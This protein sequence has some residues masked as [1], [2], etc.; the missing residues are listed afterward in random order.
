[1]N[2]L[3]VVPWD[4]ASGGVASVVGNLAKH[5]ERR[6]HSVVFLHPGAADGRGKRVTAMGFTGYEIDFRVPFVKGRPVRSVLGF[7]FY[8]AR[9]LYQIASVIRRHRIQVVNIHY[10]TESFGYIG[11]LRWLLPMRLAISVHGADLFPDG[12]GMERYPFFLKFLVWSSDAVIAPSEAFLLA[13]RS[14]F[15]GAAKKSV[16]IHNGV[17]VEEFDR[18]DEGKT[19][20]ASRPYLLCIAAHNEKKALEVLLEA[21]AQ[22]SELH[23]E[24]RLLLVG[25]GPLR[26]KNEEHARLLSLEHRVEFL[27]ER[28]RPEIGRLLRGC[29]FFVLPSRSEPFGMVIAEAMACH[30]AVVASAVG[31]IPEIV[32]N[33]KSGIL[34]EPDSPSALA[35]AL[36]TMLQDNSLREAM[37]DA[38]HARVHEHFRYERMGERYEAVFSALLAGNPLQSERATSPT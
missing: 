31:G 12:R 7:V 9:T 24:T 8:F 16:A 20:A 1:M 27:G 10:P 34:V 30:K 33:G 14:V 23:R 35:R 38:G 22:T 32:E 36:V 29:K 18:P 4:Q 17:D 25:D 3:L 11:V 21:F 19:A 28:G 5:L 26:R 15:P 13:C 6:G 2:V 37:A